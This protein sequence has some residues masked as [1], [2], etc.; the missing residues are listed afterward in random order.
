MHYYK[1]NIGDYAKKAGRLSLLQHGVYNQLIDACYDREKFPTREEAIDWVWASTEEEITA[2]DFVLAKFF[3]KKNNVYYQARIEEELKEYQSRCESNAKN[4]KKGGR[5]KNNPPETEPDKEKTQPVLDKSESE[6][7]IN[8]TETA[9]GLTTNHEPLTTIHEPIKT[10]APSDESADDA[11]RKS[12]YGFEEFYEAYPNKKDRKRA[13]TAWLKLKPDKKLQQEIICHVRLR[14][15][16]HDWRVD[17]KRYIPHPTT[18]ING[19]NWNDEITDR[20]NQHAAD[21]RSG[22]PSS[23]VDSA[24]A[25]LERRG[26]ERAEALQDQGYAENSVGDCVGSDD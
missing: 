9:A 4:G 6:P 24:R 19:E 7:N 3:T 13:M 12:D 25:E 23:P 16:L 18:F 11:W 2:V 14:L 10:L 26:R 8:P 20:R 1:K 15:E 22:K 17:E 21:S 5:P